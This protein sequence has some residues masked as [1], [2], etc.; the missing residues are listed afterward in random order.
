[1]KKRRDGEEGRGRGEGEG[2]IHFFPI[3]FQGKKRLRAVAASGDMMGR[4]APGTGLPGE[5][6]RDSRDAITT[7]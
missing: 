4:P 6:R 1:M 2:M 3:S 5:T 7:I